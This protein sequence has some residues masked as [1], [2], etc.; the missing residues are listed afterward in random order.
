[1]G[2][3]EIWDKYGDEPLRI[4]K[5][6]NNRLEC[7]QLNSN[8]EYLATA[9]NMGTIIRLFNVNN[10]ELVTEF[11]RVTNTKRIY[12]LCFNPYSNLLLCNTKC[13]SMHIFETGLNTEITSVVVPSDLIPS[14][15]KYN[16]SISR[17]R[18]DNTLCRG[19]FN[20]DNLI[21]ISYDSKY[22]QFTYDTGIKLYNISNL[23]FGKN[24]IL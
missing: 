21:M 13:G 18:I 10:G 17:Y 24:N 20:G 1:M 15:L 19:C 11:R 2:S 3:I 14:F 8:G 4:I 7:I 22:Y 12:N 6:H 9:S 16:W 5:A 23:F